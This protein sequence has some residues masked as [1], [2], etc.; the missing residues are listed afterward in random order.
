MKLNLNSSHHWMLYEQ[1]ERQTRI[2]VT[3]FET[4]LFHLLCSKSVKNTNKIIR[5]VS[6]DKK[7][8]VI[9]RNNDWKIPSLLSPD[10]VWFNWVYLLLILML[11][12]WYRF[13]LVVCVL[14]FVFPRRNSIYFFFFCCWINSSFTIF[15][16]IGIINKQPQHIT[17]HRHTTQEIILIKRKKENTKNSFEHKNRTWKLRIR[18]SIERRR[19]D[20]EW[21]IDE[22]QSIIEL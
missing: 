22:N 13:L 4:F 15:T 12:S 10:L 7:K 19:R 11:S 9:K 1:R 14:R 6:K 3:T 16:I 20:A 18:K 21:I 17:E 5:K 8:S 2:K